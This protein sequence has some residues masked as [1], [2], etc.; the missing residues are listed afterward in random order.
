MTAGQ[1]GTKQPTRSHRPGRIIERP[2]LIKQLDAA[3]APVILIV[4]PAGY[5]KTTLA[6]QWARTLS[7][8]IWVA[9]TPSHRD[10]V[11]FSEDI[12]AGIDALGGN[13]SRFVGEYIR[14]RSNPQRAAREIGGVLASRLNESQAQWLLVDDYQEI[15]NSPAEEMLSLFRERVALRILVSSRTRPTWATPRDAV[16]GRVV[17]V[18]SSDLAMT[19]TEV[20][21]VVGRRPDL[22]NLVEQARG[23]PAVITLAA[24]LQHAPPAGAVPPELHNY[25]AQE[26]FASAPADLQDDLVELALLPG[27][28]GT[29]L[30]DRFAH[31]D[32]VVERGREL[33]FVGGE[34][35]PELHPLL[36]D[37]LLAKVLELPNSEQRTRRAVELALRH[38]AWET[39]LDFVLRFELTD[40]ID[41]VVQSA[42]NPL[43]RGGR[44]GTL[45]S[46]ASRLR[47]VPGFP[48]AAV[49]VVDAEVALRDGQLELALD[50][51]ERADRRLS[52][53]HPLRCRM[54]NVRAQCLIF[55][56]DYHAA[57]HAFE[58]AR[59]ASRDE[60][61]E[62]EALHGISVSKIY[63]ELG[64]AESEMR[65][66]ADRRHASPRDL[67]RYTTSTLTS[68]RYA[69]GLSGDLGLS[70]PLH[71]LSHVEDPRARSS[72][73]YL[74]A[75]TL[76]LRCD[77]TEA[78]QFAELFAKDVTEYSLEFALPFLAWTWACIS[79]GVR[80][81]GEADRH[82]QAIEDAS[83]D[84]QQRHHEVNARVLRARLLLQ[85][86]K[87]DDAVECVSR[88]REMWR[89][90]KAWM[91]EYL[92]TRAL[93]LVAS[94]RAEEGEAVATEA[95]ATS[96]DL[97]VQVAA[98]AARAAAHATVGDSSS[99]DEM[100]RFAE[101]TDVWDPVL[102]ALRVSR[103]LTHL[104]ARDTQRKQS[105]I[106]LCVRANDQTLARQAGARMRVT[107][108]PG[109]LLSP[110][111]LE[112]LGLMAQGGRN[113]E[114]AKALFIAES[115]VKV[116]VR[117]ILEKLGVRTRAEAVARYERLQSRA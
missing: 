91:G 62:T 1:A 86:G 24:A 71:A 38:E 55:V 114:I 8:V 73:T 85:L 17:E 116:H 75:N 47:A 41:R 84:P 18:A 50:L 48:P 66:L 42:F 81:F 99:I 60:A 104:T 21:Q 4:G 101:R 72:F 89:I 26:L 93:A 49:D 39:A 12:A 33:G 5:G 108:A 27:L 34:S 32:S 80:R 52:A 74:A 7:G 77:Y 70:A 31:S 40:L 69:E 10:V 76:S 57:W 61:D 14:A 92:A 16:Y 29:A 15:L 82:L 87:P 64:E 13:A 28:R 103:E 22:T 96:R 36:R 106:R 100:L 6:R 83:S 58:E 95:Q 43:V 30:S 112:V 46:F 53:S 67:L 107:K 78:A 97:V 94:G 20:D 68:R 98:R 109:D 23:W 79:I 102:S 110:R 19:P 3:E 117:H 51:C 105:L 44:L 56:A 90:P 59:R 88:S 35:A 25:V 45:A 11:T 9:C 2:R 113:R 37:F 54:L 65:L 115:T 111:E 63:G